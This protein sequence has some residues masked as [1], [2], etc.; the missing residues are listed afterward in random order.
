[1]LASPTA[2]NLLDMFRKAIRAVNSTIRILV[3]MPAELR[4]Q[5]V[6]A[7]HTVMTSLS[8]LD[9]SGRLCRSTKPH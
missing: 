1:M 8:E 6:L 5:G 9:E 3:E 7:M 2:L 4:H